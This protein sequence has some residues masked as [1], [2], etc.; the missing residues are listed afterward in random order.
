MTGNATQVIKGAFALSVGQTDMPAPKGWEWYAL[1]DVARLESGH[2]PSRNVATYWG[3]NVPWIGIPDARKHHGATIYDTQTKTTQLGLENSSARLLPARTVCLSR[4]ASVGY[5]TVMGRSM[6]TSQDFVNW[7]CDERFLDPYFLQKI[8]IAEGP[9]L[10]RFGKGSTHTTIYFS[11]VKRFYVCLPPLEEQRRIVER[12]DGL[13]QTTDRISSTLE[14]MQHL[15]E[16]FRQSVLASA[17]RG[18]L[19]SE[20]RE[21]N[22]DVE[23]ASELLKR[24]RVERKR[25]WIE[26]YARKL[27]D[28]ARASAQKK[29]KAFT[30][31]DWQ[32]YYD[33]KLKA[34]ESKYEEPE[35]VDAEAEGLPELP[36]TWEWVRLDVLG[37][38]GTGAT[39][40]RGEAKFWYNGNIPWVTSTVVNEPVV[41]EPNDHVTDYALANTNLTLYPPG[42]ILIAMYGEGKTRGKATILGIEACT[43]QALAAISLY[44]DEYVFRRFVLNALKDNYA[45]MRRAASGGVQPNLSTSLVKEI[46]IPLAPLEEQEVLVASLAS[47]FERMGVV[48]SSY[49]SAK[50]DLERLH[51]SVLA[52]AF[53]H[54]G[55]EVP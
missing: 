50:S 13:S 35:P 34:G 47:Y 19:T 7:V 39:P 3:G 4:T 26:D 6:A 11:E 22:P 17:F 20:W 23:P 36:P 53:A 52:S 29:N 43:N 9:N 45:T 28:R 33:K 49:L 1:K 40:K 38:V 18:D 25:L 46:R 8:F 31:E 54:D 44:K 24:I 21:Q 37:A 12:L 55:A 16:R 51:K 14:D 5:A 2:T 42:T 15:L 30:D 48:Q 41:T 27:A 10:H 32:S